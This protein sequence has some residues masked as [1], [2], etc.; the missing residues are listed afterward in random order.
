MRVLLVSDWN[1]LFGGAEAYALWLRDGLRAAG[2][3]ARLLTSSVSPRARAVADYVAWAT[4]AVAGKAFLQIANPLAAVKVREVV[5][6]WRPDV[7]LVNMFALYLS[8]AAIMALGDVPFVLSITDYKPICPTGA[9]LL[10]DGSICARPAGRACLESGCLGLSH[11]LRD[12]LRY[13]LIRRAVRRA[14]AVLACSR[15][16]QRSLLAEGIVSD[17]DRL[18]VPAPRPG[19]RTLPA[20]E[21]RF[22]FV[23]RLDAEKGVETVFSAFA[24][25]RKRVPHARLRIL[26]RGPLR[27][28][29]EAMADRLGQSAAISFLGWCEPSEV[30]EEMAR[31]WTVVV[32][33]RWAEPLGFVAIEAMVRGVPALV[34]DHG[35]LAET[36]EHGVSGLRVSPGDVSA[37]AAAMEDVATGRMFPTHRLD[38]RVTARIAAEY[39]IDGHVRRMRERFFAIRG[40]R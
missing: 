3:E 5:R 29:L 4:D 11:W 24:R 39:D 38:P 15:S 12:Q 21:P 16:L 34:S 7:A 8:P 22:I 23:G 18:A 26:G 33:S 31:A 10:P 17:V 6:S 25:L 37:F 27:A 14:R 1:P 35:G 9:K 13:E 30:E 28:S 19:L 2:D 36:V 40:F 20:P 32:P